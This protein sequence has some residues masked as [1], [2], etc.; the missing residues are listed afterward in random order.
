MRRRG[1]RRGH[2][3]PQQ[4]VQY[5][6]RS[7]SSMKLYPW[8]RGVERGGLLGIT[9]DNMDINVNVVTMKKGG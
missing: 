6:E 9:Y 4:K 2:R 7:M 5:R 3:T 8:G 1:R